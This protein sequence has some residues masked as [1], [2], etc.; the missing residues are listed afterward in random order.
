MAMW[1]SEELVSNVIS[2]AASISSMSATSMFILPALAFNV[3]A[4]APVPA[5]W[6]LNS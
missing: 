5:D 6:I 1:P 3:I 4:L 2:F